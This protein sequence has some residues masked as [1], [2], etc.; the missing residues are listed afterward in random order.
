MEIGRRV[1]YEKQT[2]NVILTTT[3][4]SGDVVETTVEQDFKMY[5]PLSWLVPEA[6]GMVQLR[7]GEFAGDFAEGGVISGVDPKTEAI[8]FSFPQTDNPEEVTPPRIPLSVEIK[9]LKERQDAADAAIVM[10]MDM[11]MLNM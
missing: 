9:D 2:G 11:T 4:R 10:L 1:Y 7:Y 6:V 5:K 8:R 3:E